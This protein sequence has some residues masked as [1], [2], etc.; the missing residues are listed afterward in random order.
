MTAVEV[1]N[2]RKEFLRR[3]GRWRRRRV[4][5][6]RGITFSIEQGECVAEI[7]RAHV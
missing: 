2:L 4:P 7:G 3:E 6:L 1:T 5:A